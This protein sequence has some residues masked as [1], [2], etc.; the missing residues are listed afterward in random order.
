[1]APASLAVQSIAK[2][3]QHRLHHKYRSLA[4]RGKTPQKIVIAVAR[5]LVGF[6]WHI[7]QQRDLLAS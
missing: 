2:K 7:G 4:T 1:M 3:A 6:I 5:E